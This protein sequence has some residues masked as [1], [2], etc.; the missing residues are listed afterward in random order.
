MIYIINTIKKFNV[1]CFNRIIK[2][3]KNYW[4]ENKILFFSIIIAFFVLIIDYILVL[5]FIK[6][7]K[8]I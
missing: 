1:K 4:N 5:E 7:I 6:L 2:K 8:N 3:E